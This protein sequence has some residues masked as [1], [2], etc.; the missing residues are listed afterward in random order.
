MSDG[1]PGAGVLS[2]RLVRHNGIINSASS[3]IN[4]VFVHEATFTDSSA[5]TPIKD[6]L[7][8]RSS[9]F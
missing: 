2:L 3:Q 8:K 5:A 4:M 1:A 7:W 9:H 6:L